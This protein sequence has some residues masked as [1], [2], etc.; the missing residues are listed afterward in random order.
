MLKSDVREFILCTRAHSHS[1]VRSNTR[2]FA[3][4]VSGSVEERVN[5]SSLARCKSAVFLATS[6]LSSLSLSC[7]SR[8]RRIRIL[9][10]AER[11]INT[12]RLINHHVEYHG[13]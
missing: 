9:T 1:R 8:K 5:S 13:V 10:A 3:S 11:G 4:P 7:A 6:S 2:L 12:H